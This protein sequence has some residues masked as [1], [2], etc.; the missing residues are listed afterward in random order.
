MHVS[1]DSHEVRKGTKYLNLS[2][3]GRASQLR[4]RGVGPKGTALI[5]ELLDA[6]TT[7]DAGKLK[8][9]DIWTMVCL[10]CREGNECRTLGGR[11]RL[12]R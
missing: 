6:E 11:K 1:H 9:V 7:W 5:H 4:S 12:S 3:P 8:S 2:K 10:R